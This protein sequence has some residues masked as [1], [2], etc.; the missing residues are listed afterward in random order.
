MVLENERNENTMTSDEWA[1]VEETMCSLWPKLDL[2]QEI[3]ESWK[4]VLQKFS[5]DLVKS[6][7]RRWKDGS[8]K[9]PH[10]KDIAELINPVM[11]IPG[12]TH[13]DSKSL[14]RWEVQ[15]QYWAKRNPAKK[16]EYLGMLDADVELAVA[17]YEYLAACQQAGKTSRSSAFRYVALL[18]V[19]SKSSS[20]GSIDAQNKLLRLSDSENVHLEYLEMTKENC[21]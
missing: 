12:V 17:E 15:R 14:S 13:E 1:S 16:D 3:A 18:T 7:M 21:D 4:R 2:N 8:Q 9:Y 20:G 10:P 11:N 6:V 19:Q 5:K